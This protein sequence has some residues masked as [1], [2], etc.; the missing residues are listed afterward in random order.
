MRFFIRRK[1]L[2]IRRKALLIRR[3]ALLI[4]RKAFLLFPLLTIY[5]WDNNNMGNC[6]LFIDGENFLYKIKDVLK[7]E[8]LPQSKT[9]LAEIDLGKLFKEPLNN[10]PKSISA[11]LVLLWGRFSCFST[12]LIL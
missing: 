1:A 5:F 4:R 6:I 2:L 12:S 9:S 10:F 3:K 8:N 7:Q 11:K